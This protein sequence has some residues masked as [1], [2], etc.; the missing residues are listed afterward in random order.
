MNHDL[1]SG[2]AAKGEVV[3]QGSHSAR[4]PTAL[5]ALFSPR[6]DC[7][8]CVAQVIERTER[9]LTMIAFNMQPALY[10][11]NE[12][13]LT[14]R[15]YVMR[16]GVVLDIPAKKLHRPGD[17]SRPARSLREAS[18]AQLPSASL[19]F[20]LTFP[21][22]IPLAFPPTFL[23]TCTFSLSPALSFGVVGVLD[24]PWGDGTRRDGHT[25]NFKA[26]FNTQ[27]R[28]TAALM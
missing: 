27:A 25:S 3:Q 12:R 16:K 28:A 11:A 26:L 15:M 7:A 4:T 24:G 9:L 17:R 22:I 8:L 6:H 18:T 19:T 14:G 23:P 20:T 1:M 2:S 21:L 10:V 13:L 5:S